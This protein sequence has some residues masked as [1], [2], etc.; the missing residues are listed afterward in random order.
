VSRAGISWEGQEKSKR[1]LQSGHASAKDDLR[2]KSLLWQ[3]VTQY[4]PASCT[5]TRDS[6]LSGHAA[7]KPKHSCKGLAAFAIANAKDRGESRKPTMLER[8]TRVAISIK[9]T[10]ERRPV[11]LL[12]WRHDDCE[13]SSRNK[14]ACLI[15]A[16][17]D[18]SMRLF[19][20]NSTSKTLRAA[21]SRSIQRASQDWNLYKGAM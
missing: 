3:C 11:S 8:A 6:L 21:K 14:D 2:S 5:A 4:N 7:Y 19:E 13:E 12:L 10:A 9:E 15:D 18:T 17:R 20:F 1:L 16:L